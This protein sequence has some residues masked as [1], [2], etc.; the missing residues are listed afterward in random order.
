MAHQPAEPR[1]R[2]LWLWIAAGAALAVAVSVT[3]ATLLCN[4]EFTLTGAF[5]L[6]DLSGIT[7]GSSGSEYVNGVDC[8]GDGGYDDIRPGAQV[9]IYDETG[10]VLAAGDIGLGHMKWC[11][12]GRHAVRVRA[13]LHVQH[14]GRARS[15]RA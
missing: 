11:E 13:E 6:T 1:R 4:D 5:A 12:R 14:P 2:R 10:T 3:A 7:A 9:T 15:R 8:Q